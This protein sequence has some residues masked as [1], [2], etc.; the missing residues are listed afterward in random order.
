MWLI[1]VLSIGFAVGIAFGFIAIFT[2]A[3]WIIP[4][5]IVISGVLAAFWSAIKE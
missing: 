3:M 2:G 1:R 5:V 4:S